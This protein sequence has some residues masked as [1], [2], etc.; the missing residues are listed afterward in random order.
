MTRN[1][2]LAALLFSLTGL[3]FASF[4]TY[5][6]AS[7]LDRQVHDI[8]CSFVPGLADAA[9]SS[10][11]CQVTMMS[12]YSSVL[13]T[14]VWGGIPISLGGMAVFA[15]LGFFGTYL[16]VTGA[17]RE[18][19]ATRFYAFAWLVPV[20][21]SLVMG[22]LAIVELGAACKLCIGIY[23][24][25]FLGA[26]VAAFL[27]R[28]AG[29]PRVIGDADA[30]LVAPPQFAPGATVPTA[31]T[32][33]VVAT[34]RS[35]MWAIP[36]AG[37]FLLVPVG[38]Y[39]AAMPSYAPYEAGCGELA[40]AEDTYGVLLPLGGSVAGKTAIEVL[41][42]LC[43]SC[44]AFEGRLEASGL[45]ERLN[46]KVLLFPFDNECNW[47]LGSAVHPG[48]CA[49]SEAMLCSPANA[50]TILEWSFANQE[51]IMAAE[52]ANDGAAARMVTSQFPATRGCVGSTR[53]RSQLHRGLRW[54][55]SNQLPVLTPQLFVEGRKLCNEDTDLG[56][57]Y[58]LSRMLDGANR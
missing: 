36:L 28:E 21:T 54:A 44:K 58:T 42:P 15:F 47:M 30:T 29:K 45:D 32:T 31:P 25:S 39:V 5:D 2:A 52:R 7:H 34:G 33:S 57:E 48:A 22:Y 13:R 4:S 9:T 14:A 56:L 27:A 23:A 50:S 46:R 11:G 24:S 19:R 1:L 40:H 8:H 51:A 49:I 17:D 10:S 55:S 12:R 6:F 37:V 18:Q 35:V 43:A 41:D 53:I 20:L 38:A 16:L 26:I 3:G